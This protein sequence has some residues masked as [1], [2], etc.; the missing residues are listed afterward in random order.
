MRSAPAGW[1][2]AVSAVMGFSFALLANLAEEVRQDW[3]W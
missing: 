2:L 3:L 1:V